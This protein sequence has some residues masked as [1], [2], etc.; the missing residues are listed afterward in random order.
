[1]NAV[2]GTVE[3]LFGQWSEKFL[4]S[5]AITVKALRPVETHAFQV[6]SLLG[7]VRKELAEQASMQSDLNDVNDSIRTRVLVFGFIS[8]AIMGISTY[9]Q[10]RYLKNFFRHKKII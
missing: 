7:Q 1:M 3:L 10:V 9:L 6:N 8:V 5:Q 4:E 2:V